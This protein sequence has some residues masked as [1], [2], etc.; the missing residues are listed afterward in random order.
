M[1]P[2][3]FFYESICYSKHVLLQHAALVLC[4][5]VGPLCYRL[6]FAARKGSGF[7]RSAWA[8]SAASSSLPPS[9]G[10]IRVLR[11]EKMQRHPLRPENYSRETLTSASSTAKSR[12]CL[13]CSL[14]LDSRVPWCSRLRLRLPMYRSQEKASSE[15]DSLRGA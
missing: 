6:F 14:V 7:L 4:F 11:G 9:Y 10:K 13:G 5:F 3:F 8:L 1:T 12:P 15:Q 2:P